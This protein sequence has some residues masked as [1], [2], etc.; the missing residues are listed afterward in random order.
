MRRQDHNQAAQPQRT[1]VNGDALSFAVVISQGK[2]WQPA[3]QM[4]ASAA[5]CSC[6]YQPCIVKGRPVSSAQSV[7]F[8]AICIADLYKPLHSSFESSQRAPDA[9]CRKRTRSAPDMDG[10]VDE[11][12]KS[13]CIDGAKYRHTDSLGKALAHISLLPYLA[14]FYQAAVVYSRR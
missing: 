11:F 4:L 8:H 13:A 3:A 2:Q 9:T 14:L 5:P 6:C 1:C 12:L 7:S 10:S